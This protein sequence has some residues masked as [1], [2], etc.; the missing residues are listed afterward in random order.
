M[1]GMSFGLV[2]LKLQQAIGIQSM[3]S[4]KQTNHRI[5]GDGNRSFIRWLVWHLPFTYGICSIQGVCYKWLVR[6]LYYHYRDLKQLP[7]SALSSCQSWCYR[8]QA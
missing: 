5:E 4:Q 1:C 6:L 7:L 8:T 2:L 3:G